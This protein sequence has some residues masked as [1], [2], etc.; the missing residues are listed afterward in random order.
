MKSPSDMTRTVDF[1]NACLK[2]KP[3]LSGSFLLV[4]YTC[5]TLITGYQETWPSQHCNRLTF[6]QRI[7]AKHL[8]KFSSS[9][10]LGEASNFSSSHLLAC[11]AK[12]I[13]SN[14]KVNY[15]HCSTNSLSQNP[16]VVGWDSFQPMNER[17][18]LTLHDNK[19]HQHGFISAPGT[20]SWN[21]P[22][23]WPSQL[24]VMALQQGPRDSFPI[25][26]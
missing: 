12:N 26:G 10:L 16:E 3:M 7:T 5:I 22:I 18:F 23:Q 8:P 2:A 17:L 9:C 24:H 6:V 1:R 15:S 14:N 4:L 13:L 11:G 25:L 20:T 21:N 19:K